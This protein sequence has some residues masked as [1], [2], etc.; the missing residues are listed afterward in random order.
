MGRVGLVIFSRLDSSRLPGKA[1]LDIAGRPMLSWVIERL[2]CLRGTDRIVVATTDRD[3]DDPIVKLA[4]F[5]GVEVFRGDVDNVAGRALACCE[6]FGFE[7]MARICGDSPLLD[8][9]LYQSALARDDTAD[10]DLISNVFPR[11][12]PTGAS[13]ELVSVMAL[14]TALS[15]TVDDQDREHMTRYFYRKSERFRI[16]NLSAPDDRYLGV[17]LVVDTPRDLERVRFIMHVDRGDPCEVDLERVCDLARQ[18]DEA[19]RER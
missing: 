10:W 14:R 15:G 16:L 9:S 17:R 2:R 3:I 1:L 8:V 4:E 12:Y 5:E 7:R 18:W 11:S 13:M 6:H 19:H